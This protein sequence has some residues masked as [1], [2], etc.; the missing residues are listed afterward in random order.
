MLVELELPFLH[1]SDSSA[2]CITVI[3]PLS[4]TN[5][6]LRALRTIYSIFKIHHK[7]ETVDNVSLKE[8]ANS[9]NEIESDM[10]QL[11]K[12]H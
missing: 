1:L 7:Y 3:T 9:L 12:E 4:G 2:E 8:T 6:N 11:V 5:P 10:K